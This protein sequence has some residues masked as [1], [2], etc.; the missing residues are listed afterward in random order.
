VEVILEHAF[1]MAREVVALGSL[2]EGAS[3]LAEA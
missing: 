3:Y 2:E 1:E